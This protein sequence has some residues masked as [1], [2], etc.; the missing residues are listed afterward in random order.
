MQKG[1]SKTRMQV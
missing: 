1:T